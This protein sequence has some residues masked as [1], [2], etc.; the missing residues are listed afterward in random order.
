MLRRTRV[1]FPSVLGYQAIRDFKSELT[2]LS[3]KLSVADS[4]LKRSSCNH[5]AVFMAEGAV[6]AV[7]KC[8]HEHAA[9]IKE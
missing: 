3:G 9:A 6:A 5:W 7:K 4:V 1:C 8:D 2:E